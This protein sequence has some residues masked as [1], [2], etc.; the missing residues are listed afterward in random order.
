VLAALLALTLLV[1]LA[2]PASAAPTT[3]VGTGDSGVVPESLAACAGPGHHFGFGQSSVLAQ[4]TGQQTLTAV[5]QPVS[6]NTTATQPCATAAG[7]NC[8][9][10]GQLNGSNTKNNSGIVVITATAPTPVNPVQPIIFART[11]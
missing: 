11:T 6:L 9:I 5:G 10:T 7:Q 8:P 1:G 3:V 4:S 2:L